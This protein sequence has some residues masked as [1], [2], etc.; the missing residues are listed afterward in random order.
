LRRGNA[1]AD[2]ATVTH[3][4]HRLPATIPARRGMRTS[5][6]RGRAPAATEVAAGHAADSALDARVPAPDPGRPSGALSS[7]RPAFGHPTF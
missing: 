4:A 5:W 3:R 7:I 1:E 6:F 2:D